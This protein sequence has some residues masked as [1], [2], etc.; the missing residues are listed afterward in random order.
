MNY[1]LNRQEFVESIKSGYRLGYDQIRKEFEIGKYLL[2]VCYNLSSHNDKGLMMYNTAKCYIPGDIIY[3]EDHLSSL[4]LNS[5]KKVRYND[6]DIYN[7][8][9]LDLYKIYL[10]I[11][12][13]EKL[14][15]FE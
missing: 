1:L 14:S 4:K 5:L 13:L 8:T 9:Q 11:I 10:Y 15:T 2:I 6:G 7:L 3:W 12:R